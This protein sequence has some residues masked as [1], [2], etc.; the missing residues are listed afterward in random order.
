MKIAPGCAEEVNRVSDL[1]LH[2]FT[3]ENLNSRKAIIYYHGGGFV[4][5]SVGLYRKFL[6]NMA[7]N[8]KSK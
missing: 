4:I 2:I 8:I 1:D 5:G 3:P 6:S 7:R